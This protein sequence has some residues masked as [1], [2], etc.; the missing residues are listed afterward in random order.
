VW[1]FFRERRI[2]RLVERI[3]RACVFF[4][5]N[6]E[7][8]LGDDEASL[9]VALGWGFE[10][11]GIRLTRASADTLIYEDMDQREHHRIYLVANNSVVIDVRAVDAVS[12]YHEEQLIKFLRHN[13]YPIGL[14]VNFGTQRFEPEIN[15]VDKPDRS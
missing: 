12:V 7:F 13:R 14:V 1:S 9:R 11:I 8:R 4:H 5:Q 6:N 2:A 10:K 15:E 3:S